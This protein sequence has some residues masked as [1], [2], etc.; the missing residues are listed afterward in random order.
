MPRPRRLAEFN[1]RVTNR[2]ALRIAGWAPGF[3]IVRH[4][5]R[6]S[7]TEYHTPVNVFREDDGFLF[8]LT[9]GEGSWVRNVMA[10]GGC[11]IRTRRQVIELTA[12][13]LDTDP[14][15]RGIPIPTRWILG[16]VDVDEFLSLRRAR[17]PSPLSS[18]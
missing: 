11:S 9:Y 6:R 13:R 14:T 2:V 8:A 3:A 10:A 12:P 4:I 18:S 16:L 15:R 5:G 1:K 7:G 17:A